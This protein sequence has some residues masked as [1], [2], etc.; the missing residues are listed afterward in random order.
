CTGRIVP[1]D[2]TEPAGIDVDDPERCDVDAVGI[3][4]VPAP[5]T[6]ASTMAS[7]TAAATQQKLSPGQSPG[8]SPRQTNNA[9]QASV[10]IVEVIGYGGGDKP[11]DAP[12]EQ[13]NKGE[14]TLSC[15]EDG[16]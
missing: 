4:T 2:S 11:N 5:P 10:I 3:P 6:S 16:T 1:G 15:E 12:Q 7:S 9:G 13:R 8:Q 14:G